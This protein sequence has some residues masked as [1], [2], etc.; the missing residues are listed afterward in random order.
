M[1]FSQDFTLNYQTGS[2]TIDYF[3][4]DFRN[5]VVLDY[6]KSAREAN[7]FGLTGRSYSHSLQLQTDYQLMRRFDIR[8]A[9][10]WL[11]VETDY[12]NGLLRRPLV[13][14]NRAFMNLAYET[15]NKWKFDYT[16]QVTGRQRI[17][18]TSVNPEAYRLSAYSPTYALMN[19]QVT[20]DLGERW[21]LYAG[22]ENI[23][24][25]RLSHPIVASDAPFSPYFDSS[26]VWGPVFGRMAYAGFRYR[27]K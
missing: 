26:L 4:T 19:A 22:M 13:P 24:G 10:R 5:Q 16:L 9:Y 23:T 6:D 21:S 27:V 12:L 3:F 20:K 18:D 2:I 25:F 15:K 11:D 17:P 1:N 8:L 7:F 14:V